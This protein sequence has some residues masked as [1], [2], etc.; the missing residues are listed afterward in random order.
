[1]PTRM[2][3]VL[4]MRAQSNAA[5]SSEYGF[6]E[7]ISNRMADARSLSETPGNATCRTITSSRGKSTEAARWAAP[8][9]F[10]NAA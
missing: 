8:S 1:M 9:F 5:S 2:P 6:S 10:K 3:A 7:S 4:P